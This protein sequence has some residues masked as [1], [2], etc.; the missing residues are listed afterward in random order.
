M[1]IGLLSP[2]ASIDL[3]PERSA[4]NVQVPDAEMKTYVGPEFPQSHKSS[5]LMQFSHPSPHPNVHGVLGDGIMMGQ[6]IDRSSSAI[7]PPFMGHHP[8]L[9][10]RRSDPGFARPPT[11]SRNPAISSHM[12][13]PASAMEVNQARLPTSRKGET[14]ESTVKP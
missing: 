5:P 14:S 3:R 12:G 7:Y 4:D 13:L 11:V 6:R 9:S 8:P 1:R 10:T 2:R